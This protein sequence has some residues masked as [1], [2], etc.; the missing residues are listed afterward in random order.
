MSA[1]RAGAAEMLAE[2]IY[3][4][5]QELGVR[6][7]KNVFNH[8][9]RR[10]KETGVVRNWLSDVFRKRY[11][12]KVRSMRYN[13]KRYPALREVTTSGRPRV[14]CRRLVDMKARELRGDEDRGVG[15]DEKGAGETIDDFQRMVREM[16]DGVFRC[17]RCKSKKT[18]YYE[19]QTRC[20]DEPMTV[21]VTCVNCGNRWRG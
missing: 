7:E 8:T 15:A 14:S 1:V 11:V 10:A 9:L 16:P 5:N 3:G 13:L 6:L 12:W 4:G 19:M 21:F 2:E 18:T 20:A 17:G